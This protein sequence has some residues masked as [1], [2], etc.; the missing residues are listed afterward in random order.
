MNHPFDPSAIRASSHRQ[1]QLANSNRS[2][3]TA[4]GQSRCFREGHG[5]RTESKLGMSR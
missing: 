4:K 3:R 1:I 5:E 2:T